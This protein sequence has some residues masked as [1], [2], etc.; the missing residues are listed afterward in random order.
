MAAIAGLC[1]STGVI[2]YILVGY[3]LLPAAWRDHARAVAQDPAFRPRVTVVMAVYNGAAF[4]RKKLEVDSE[5][6]LPKASD[7]DS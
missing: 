1:L 4:F 3:P 2:F 6:R 7:A 5:S